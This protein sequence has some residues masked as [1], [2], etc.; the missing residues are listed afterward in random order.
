[1][2]SKIIVKGYQIGRKIDQI[3]LR[4]IYQG[5]EIR[6]GKEVF[7]TVIS[8]RPGRSMDILTKRAIQSKKIYMPRLVTAIS[9]GLTLDG[10]FYYVHQATPSFPITQVLSEIPNEN[11]RLFTQI[12]FFVE[13]AL[14]TMI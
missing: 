1:M 12:R 10:Q 2:S 3:G 6:T 7:I 8:V 5:L 9:H 14:I 11:E 4:T 13:L